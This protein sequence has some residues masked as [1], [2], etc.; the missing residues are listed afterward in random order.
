MALREL[1]RE[2]A[3][4]PYADLS[5]D[6]RLDQV[7][8]D[9]GKSAMLSIISHCSPLLATAPRDSRLELYI[10]RAGV[11]QLRCCVAGVD[12]GSLAAS[13]VTICC[14]SPFS[15]HRFPC[16]RTRVANIF[17]ASGLCKCMT[18]EVVEHLLMD[19]FTAAVSSSGKTVCSMLTSHYM[20]SVWLCQTTG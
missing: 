19:P 18:Q 6:S 5:T 13:L 14:C 17:V 3:I 1:A 12:L 8:K 4:W 15:P 20:T 16:S 10:K 9:E 2:M 11:L 7:K